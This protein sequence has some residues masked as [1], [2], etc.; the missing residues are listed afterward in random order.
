MWCGDTPGVSG[1]TAHGRSRRRRDR[2]ASRYVCPVTGVPWLDEH[3]V[4]RR[5][6]QA[7]C[8]RQRM[9]GCLN[10]PSILLYVGMLRPVGQVNRLPCNLYAA[11]V[12]NRKFVSAAKASSPKFRGRYSSTNASTRRRREARSCRGLPALVG[13][14][15]GVLGRLLRSAMFTLTT[16]Y[17]KRK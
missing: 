9:Y 12:Q 14:Q 5:V 13:T 15:H 10:V 8:I 16:R 11:A 1:K 2:A 6:F 4:G 3:S 7:R 17:C